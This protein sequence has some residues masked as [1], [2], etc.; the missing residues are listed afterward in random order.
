V[1]EKDYLVGSVTEMCKYI[2]EYVGKMD[3][4]E[5][6]HTQ[7][8]VISLNLDGGSVPYIDIT[9]EERHIF[10]GSALDTSIV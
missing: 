5:L 8:V 7:S 10:P 2:T 4:D 9:R 1:K 6:S 3:E